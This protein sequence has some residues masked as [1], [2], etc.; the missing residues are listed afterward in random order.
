MAAI[1]RLR[2]RMDE[3]GFTQSELAGRANVSQSRISE[4]LSGKRRCEQMRLS[5]AVRLASALGVPLDFFYE[6]VS[7][8]RHN[9]ICS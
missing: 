5:T 7:S 6:P 1:E 2:A 9:E 4:L 8:E 3:L